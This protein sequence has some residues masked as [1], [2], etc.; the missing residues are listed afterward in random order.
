MGGVQVG[1][2]DAPVGWEVL[3]GVGFQV[4]LHGGQAGAVL[5]AD[6]AL[7]RRGASVGA[8]VLDHG[9]VVPRTLAAQATLERLLACHGGR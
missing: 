3:D 2:A 5:Q 9:R 8:Q 7:V 4:L 6:G 1:A